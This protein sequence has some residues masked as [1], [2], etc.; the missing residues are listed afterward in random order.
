[1]NDDEPKRIPLKDLISEDRAHELATSENMQ[2]YLQLLK[3]GLQDRDPTPHGEE[4]AK[5]NLHEHQ[6]GTSRIC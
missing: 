2:P 4:I 3:A 6:R 5:I 1:M